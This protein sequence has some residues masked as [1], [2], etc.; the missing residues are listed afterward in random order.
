MHSTPKKRIPWID[1]AKGIAMLLVF[2]GHVGGGGDNPWFP[3]LEG[4]IWVVYRFHMPL[5]LILSGLT[6]NP[7]KPFKPFLISRFKRLVIPYYFFSL[8]ALAKIVVMVASPSVYAGFHSDTMG[9]PIAELIKIILGQASG[10][11]FFLALF[12][13]DLVLYGIHHFMHNKPYRSAVLWTVVIVCSYAWFI[14]GSAGWA[15]SVPFQLFHGVEA[16]AFVGFGWLFSHW[17]KALNRRQSFL[18][19]TASTVFFIAFVVLAKTVPTDTIWGTWAY[20]TISIVMAVSGS[21]LVIGLCQIL[22]A[23]RWIRYIGRNTMVFYGLNGLSLA[24]S[25]TAIFACVSTSIV[26]ANVWLQLFVGF[27]VIAVACGI[28]SVATPLLNRWCWW[29][30]GLSRPQKTKTLTNKS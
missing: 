27:F 13:G 17:I 20:R 22:P 4:S 24:I 5:F 30:I 10:L 12:W 28:C 14:W 26:A 15:E 25:R 6:F 3:N 29:G 8:Y 23:I 18:M 7:D 16:V 2:Y 1:V 9:G 11:W 21:L 19:M